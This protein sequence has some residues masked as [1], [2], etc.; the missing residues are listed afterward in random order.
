MEDA[1]P[2]RLAQPVAVRGPE[3][4]CEDQR[5]RCFHDHTDEQNADQH[6]AHVTEAGAFRLG[7]GRYPGLQAQPAG[8]QDPKQGAEGHHA[9]P[10][11][12]DEDQD[13]HLAEAAP[14]DGCVHGDQ[15]GDTDGGGGREQ[16][17]QQAGPASVRL[18]HREQQQPGPDSDGGGEAQDNHLRRMARRDH[19]EEP[20]DARRQ[21]AQ[22]PRE[23]RLA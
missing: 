4:G 5:Q 19:P 23:L 15:A 1:M 9:E 2:D 22:D 3:A 17:L 8:S 12:L 14:E 20:G 10:A 11:D 13:D 6:A 16:R 7:G 21:G 18:G